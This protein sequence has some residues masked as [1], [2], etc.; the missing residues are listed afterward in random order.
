[1]KMRIT[2]KPKTNKGA[3]VIRFHRVKVALAL[4]LGL[5]GGASW[6]Y[7]I[8]TTSKALASVLEPKT[9]VFDNSETFK[10]L[11]EAKEQE[12]K[13]KEPTDCYSAAEKYAPL[14]GADTELLKRIITAESG[15]R[16]TVE[17]K[18]SSATGCFQWILSTWR[19]YGKELWG[20]SFYEKN[21]YSF[22][23]NTE[24]AAYVIGKYGKE[25][26]L[27]EWAESA[28]KWNK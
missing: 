2:K 12:E 11:K 27:K 14:Y 5:I 25:R 8:Q 1:M 26:A 7:T 17:N 18:L 10:K 4:I 22:N 13:A 15:N 23:D 9:H 3:N 20:S 24:L 16:R 19:Y 6:V 21:Q 28:Y